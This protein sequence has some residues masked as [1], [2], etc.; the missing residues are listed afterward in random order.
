[1]VFN[2][3]YLEI[4]EPESGLEC[5]HAVVHVERMRLRTIWNLCMSKHFSFS[6]AF[7]WKTFNVIDITCFIAVLVSSLG[8]THI[9]NVVFEHYTR[10]MRPAENWS[11]RQ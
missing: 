10:Q 8:V 2:F 7:Y 11:L 5:D 1:M 3:N 4:I 6:A 9:S